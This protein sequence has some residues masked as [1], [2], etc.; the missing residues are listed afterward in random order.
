ML[1]KLLTFLSFLLCASAHGG[2]GHDCLPSG[3]ADS[4]F[5]A[6]VNAFDG[7]TDG[8]AEL[9]KSFAEDFTFYSQSNWWTSPHG[10]KFH[11]IHTQADPVCCL[12][13]SSDSSNLHEIVPQLSAFPR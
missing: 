7:V 11:D 6:Y 12:P 1:M 8:G 5:K 9:N 3:Q 13:N 2:K 10:T 4:L